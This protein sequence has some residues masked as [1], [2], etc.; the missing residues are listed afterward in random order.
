MRFTPSNPATRLSA[1]LLLSGVAFSQSATD[2]FDFDVTPPYR[3]AT[4]AQYAGWDVFTV[5]F[6]GVNL[7]DDPA[8]DLPATLEQ[9]VPGAIITSTMNIYSPGAAS[10]FVVDVSV[11]D[12]LRTALLQVRSLGNPLD[13]ATFVLTY[14]GTNGPEEVFPT[15]IQQLSPAGGFAAEKAFEFDLGGVAAAVTDFELRFNAAAPNCSLSAVLLDVDLDGEIGTSY[16][17]VAPNSTGSIGELNAFGSTALADN[18]VELRLSQLP[19]STFGV[20]IVSQIQDSVPFAGGGTGTLCLGGSI[21]RFSPFSADPSGSFIASVDVNQ[22]AAPTGSVPAQP[23]ETWNFQCWHR[24]V[25][26]PPTSC[27]TEAVAIT[28]Q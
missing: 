1:L 9:T 20:L 27:F 24:D 3:G 8:S 22:I 4:T 14:Q 19:G 10:A 28:F 6:G 17:S 15:S 18:E 25:G 13:D 23:G 12:P 7:P 5:A 26:T 2:A 11:A 21:G 16:C